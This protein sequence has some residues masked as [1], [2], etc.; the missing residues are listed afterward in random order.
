MAGFLQKQ[1]IPNKTNYTMERQKMIC[2]PKRS[3][4]SAV[5]NM[6]TTSNFGQKEHNPKSSHAFGQNRAF[7]E[8]FLWVSIHFPC[9]ITIQFRHQLIKVWRFTLIL[10][11]AEMFFESPNFLGKKCISKRKISTIPETNRTTRR[12]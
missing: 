7:L 11:M 4:S 1:I 12:T 10:G 2:K 8:G 3:K 5:T 6:I 9:L